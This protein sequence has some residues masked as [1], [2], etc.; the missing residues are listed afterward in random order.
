MMWRGTLGVAAMM[1]TCAAGARAEHEA[2]RRLAKRIDVSFIETPL[3]R[4]VQEVGRLA[5]VAVVVD[6]DELD[7]DE[8]LQPINIAL[9]DISAR[10]A[11]DVI[12]K[13][14]CL[15][16][17]PDG[18]AVRL[19]SSEWA[20]GEIV[21]LRTFDVRD[22]T[23]IATDFPGPDFNSAIPA[24]RCGR[25]SNRIISEE[26]SDPCVDADSFSELVMSRI[27]PTEW[28]AALGTSIEMRD[29]RLVVMH[30]P[31]VLEEIG[32]LI[33]TIRE[34]METAVRIESAAYLVSTPILDAAI[35]KSRTPGLLKPDE[36]RPFMSALVAGNAR[37]LGKVRVT[38]FSTQR[39]HAYAGRIST[40]VRDINVIKDRLD[41][42]VGSSFEG[43]SLDIRPVASHDDR[44]VTFSANVQA[45][46][47]IAHPKVHTVLARASPTVGDGTGKGS[48]A[49]GG[50]V[51]EG[52][53][54]RRASRFRIR[55]P[56]I[57]KHEARVFLQIPSGHSALHCVPAA[58]PCDEGMS[59]VFVIRPVISRSS[60]EARSL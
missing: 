10:Q 35:D 15:S 33:Q 6:T 45:T 23:Y 3:E 5:N 54:T 60:K 8:F 49:K 20:V 47:A 56:D 26:A 7:T 44:F 57:A 28:D 41:L 27:H 43:Y 1:L 12:L 21:V 55:T 36:S 58:R 18:Y 39:V 42:V 17:I 46:E 51:G 11:L 38:C 9:K 13:A 37:C 52:A 48:R 30:R 29:G 34:S 2:A 19:V 25:T 50:A 14:S 24:G 31:Q 4:A 40:M 32:R 16:A 53:G 22:L 59:V